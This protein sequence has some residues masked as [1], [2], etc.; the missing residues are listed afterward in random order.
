LFAKCGAGNRLPNLFAKC[1]AGNRLPN[2]FAKCGAGNRL[3]NLFAKCGASDRLLCN[4]PN[5]A[6]QLWLANGLFYSRNFIISSV[7]PLRKLFAGPDDPECN[8]TSN[9]D[10]QDDRRPNGASDFWQIPAAQIE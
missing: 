10:E 4:S 8:H 6:R 7:L 3:P 2:L 5:P 9:W 1:G